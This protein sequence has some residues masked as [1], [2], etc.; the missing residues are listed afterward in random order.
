MSKSKNRKIL[1][2]LDSFFV[3]IYEKKENFFTGFYILRCLSCLILVIF[4]ILFFI[5]FFNPQQRAVTVSH[6]TESLFNQLRLEYGATLS[7]PCTN[8]IMPYNVFVSNTISFHPVCSSIFVSEEWIAALYIEYA[9]ALLV[10]DFRTTAMSQVS[11][12]FE[13]KY[14]FD[15]YH[16]K[17]IP[18]LFSKNDVL[19]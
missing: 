12:F 6:I 3:R 7:C 13:L 14:I 1:T 10:M 9:S 16:I 8:I 4:Y 11:E 19:F 5:A 15:Y 18:D 17:H 2:T